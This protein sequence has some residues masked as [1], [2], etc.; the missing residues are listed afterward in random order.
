MTNNQEFAQKSV[1]RSSKLYLRAGLHWFVSESALADVSSVIPS[2]LRQ[3]KLFRRAHSRCPSYNQR[4][5]LR[6]KVHLTGVLP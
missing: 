5:G 4:L 6:G 1:D 2:E 3:E